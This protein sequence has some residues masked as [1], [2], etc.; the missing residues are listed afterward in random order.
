MIGALV[1]SLIACVA[2]VYV[3]APLRRPDEAVDDATPHA[4]E[5]ARETKTAALTAIIDL[6]EE[7]QVGKLSRSE[8][9]VLRTEYE[10]EALGALDEIDALTTP[11]GAEP[12]PLEAEIEAMR[13]RLACPSCG[14]MREPGE[15]CSRCGA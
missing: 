14:A 12:D 10:R 2:L 1:V 5:R 13:Q 7:A 4:L 6:E 15:T 3:V 11:G 9:E 8:L